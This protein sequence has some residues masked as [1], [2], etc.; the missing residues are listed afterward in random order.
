MTGI[1][2]TLPFLGGLRCVLPVLFWLPIQY[3]HQ[4]MI[5]MKISAGRSTIIMALLRLRLTLEVTNTAPDYSFPEQQ[6]NFDY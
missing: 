3:T 4:P 2:V 1:T 6:I 5:N